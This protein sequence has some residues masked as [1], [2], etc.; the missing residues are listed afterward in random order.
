MPTPLL[1]SRDPSLADAVLASAAAVRVEPVI[2][3]DTEA[4]RRAWPGADLVLVGVDLAATVVGLGLP[5]RR[6]VHVCGPDADSLLA[7]S[8]PLEAPAMVLPEQSGFLSS[9]L[10][11]RDELRSDGAAVLRLV[12]GSG[13]LG[14]TT[15]AAGLA[16]RAQR[17]GL[18]A[19]LVELDPLGGGIDLLFGAEQAPG[20]RWPDLSSAAGHVGD[21]KGQLPNVSGVDIVSMGRPALPDDSG[22]SGEPG[23]PR[24]EAVHAVLAGLVRGRELVVLDAGTH[25]DPSFAAQAQTLLVVGAEVKAVVAARARAIALRLSGAQ[26]V[27]RTGP[28]RRLDPALVADTLGMPLCGTVGHAGWLPQALESGEPP[29]LGRRRFSRECDRI[30]AEALA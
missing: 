14:T 20:W 11:G 2:A 21:L 8:V 27:V 19:A 16:Q 28:G 5:P 22:G 24:P 30:L 26:L 10:V 25:P 6:G 17:R 3:R 1:I 15:L 9:L 13:G 7:W 29:G 23:L 4:I 18:D 12:G